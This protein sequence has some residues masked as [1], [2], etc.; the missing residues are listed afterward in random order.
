MIFAFYLSKMTNTELNNIYKRVSEYISS[1]SLERAFTLLRNTA[2]SAMQWEVTDALNHTERNYRYLLGYLSDG[3]DDPQRQQMLDNIVV[4]TY[5][6][7]DTLT[8]RLSL[9]DNSSLYYNTLRTLGMQ[10][11]TLRQRF[12]RYAAIN[13]EHAVEQLL[14]GQPAPAAAEVEQ[15]ETDIFNHIWVTFPLSSE[16][17]DT[18]DAALDSEDIPQRL[19]ILI[20]TALMFALEQN[21]DTRAVQLLMREYT[22]QHHPS[23]RMPALV[24]LLLTLFRYRRRPLPSAV[25]DGIATLRS[26]PEWSDDV[27]TVFIELIQTRDTDRVSRKM[28]NTIIPGMMS[29]KDDITRTMAESD[30]T[31]DGIEANPEWEEILKKSGISD[32]LR[33]LNEMQSRGADIFMATFAHLKQFPF[34]SVMPDWFVPFSVDRSQVSSLGLA[35]E[36]VSLVSTLPFICDND[37]YSMVFALN[38]LP[39]NQH[40]AMLSQL[41]AQHDAIIEEIKHSAVESQTLVDNRRAARNYLRNLYRFYNLYRRKGDFKN[42]FA[43]GLNLTAVPALKPDFDNPEHVR[44]IAEFLLNAEYWDEAAG[45]F[46]LLDS[47]AGP[48]E[49]VFQKL[50]YAYHRMGD[51]EHAVEYYHQAEV[52]TPGSKW[53]IARLAEAYTALKNNSQAIRYLLKLADAAPEDAHI[54]LEL[55]QLYIAD[56]NI[57]EALGQLHKAEYLQPD[58][59]DGLRAMVRAQLLAAKPDEAARY[60]DRVLASADIRSEDLFMAGHIAMARHRYGEAVNLYRRGVADRS[61]DTLHTAYKND[62]DVMR[63]LGIPQTTAAMIADAVAY[64]LKE[65]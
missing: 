42:P 14:T 13:P 47:I 30:L 25:A 37:K 50:G 59:I 53:L 56:G 6:H 23:V 3:A 28:R 35:P 63:V 7:L 2:E 8:R 41:E 52:F 38:M 16:N 10:R 44:V 29:V 62:A 57:T 48:D 55:A 27:Q 45:A 12:E 22:R 51:C 4:E 46:G 24:A 64:R 5:R 34:F 61:I 31:P 21:F 49:A 15:A 33:E 36:I 58:N 32:A 19:K 43:A 65:K 60:N 54:A 20:V 26:L 1:G 40:K 9:R 39:Q 11:V 18:I 17:F